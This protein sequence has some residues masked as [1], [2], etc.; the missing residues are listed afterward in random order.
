MR[1]TRDPVARFP[2]TDMLPFLR[3]R[4]RLNPPTDAF[5]RAYFGLFS[6][7]VKERMVI[8]ISARSSLAVNTQKKKKTKQ[9]NFCTVSKRGFELLF[10]LT[11]LFKALL[12]ES[13]L[14]LLQ[15]TILVHFSWK[16]QLFS[17][18]TA[19]TKRNPYMHQLVV[20]V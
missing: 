18:N 6:V 4:Q 19:S 2:F 12:L 15:R 5:A 14:L 13:V 20:V 8:V 11:G 7:R 10:S 17:N 9:L 1:S 3:A 16:Q